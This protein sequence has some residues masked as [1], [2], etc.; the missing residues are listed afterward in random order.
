V[1]PVLCSGHGQYGG[2]LCHCEEGW[3]G[4]ECDIPESD[5]RVADCSG[6]GQCVRGSCH[7]K[8][9]WKGETCDEPD[10]E[11][12]TCSEHGACVH[13]QCYCKAGWK[14]PRCDVIDEQVHKCL[15][16]CSD[17]GVY[18]LEAAKCI[19]NRHWTGPD[20]SQGTQR[21]E[22][23]FPESLSDIKTSEA[24][25]SF[26]PSTF[27]R[28][29]IEPSNNVFMVPSDIALF[30]SSPLQS[31]LRPP[32]KMRLGQVQVRPGMDGT[33]VRT[34]ALRSQVPGARSVQERN[35]RVFARVER[36]PL[37]PT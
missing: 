33:E 10:C 23:S 17:H 37:H 4:A 34:A 21:D 2:G 12:P 27:T 30:R 31:G 8:P 18:D 26:S 20:C 13:G 5:C 9:G 15:P 35:V 19:C 6:H 1:C 36:T 32:R 24:N 22:K 14:G 3:K 25:S 28:R 11:D 29:Y 7:C 16:T